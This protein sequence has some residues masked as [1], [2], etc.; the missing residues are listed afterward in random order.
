MKRIALALVLVAVLVGSGF[1]GIAYANSNSHQPMKG[2]KLVG[3]GTLGHSGPTLITNRERCQSSLFRIANPDCVESITIERVSII[4]AG[5]T[6]ENELVYEGPLW[7]FT[8]PPGPFTRVE[9]S[10]LPP[11]GVAVI[12]L[13]LWMPDEEPAHSPGEE[14]LDYDL[15]INKTLQPY[16][17]EI[18]YSTK[19]LELIGNGVIYDDE[20]FGNEQRW[21]HRTW[22]TPM[23]NM[24][25]K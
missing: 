16:T 5:G 7:V 11:H 18:H 14:W 3:T 1:A 12:N 15:A 9:M 20:Y 23:V 22:S 4:R 10:Q 19:G 8:N 24:E 17:V 6:A 13:P 2:M 21:A 25:Q